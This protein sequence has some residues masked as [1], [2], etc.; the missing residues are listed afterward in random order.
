M[1][2]SITVAR[3]FYQLE[4]NTKGLDRDL[5][6]AEKSF[7]RTAAFIKA[8]PVVAVAALGT[9]MVG[10]ALKATEMASKFE[11]SMAEVST[12]VDTTSVDMKKLADGVLGLYRNLPVE[13]IDDLTKGLYNV[14]SAGVP[15]GEAIEFLDIAARAAV[16]G[17]TNVNTAVGGLT[18]AVNSF[19]T[20]GVTA[21]EAADKFFVAVKGG[22]T[23][24]E[25]ISGSIGNV[26]S[27]ANSLGVSLDDLL[28]NMVALTK[29][30]INTSTAFNSLRQVLSNVAKPTAELRREYPEL[31]K[32]FNLTSLKAK[33]LTQFMLDLAPALKGNDDAAVKMFGSVEALNAVMGLTADGG[34]EL[35]RIQDEMTN[36]AGASAA[37]FDKMA[38]T[39]ANL[40]QIMKNQFA[41]SM[42]ELGV[43][44]LPTVNYALQAMIGFFDTL[45]GATK[46][47]KSDDAARSIGTIATAMDKLSPESRARDLER[48]RLAMIQLTGAVGNSVVDFG[49]FAG[50]ARQ[51]GTEAEK[52][53]TGALQAL[54]KG[55]SAAATS[56]ELTTTQMDHVRRALNGV[57]TELSSRGEQIIPGSA[58]KS[59]EDTTG[60][61]GTTTGALGDLGD[62]AGEAAK[63]AQEAAD[64]YAAGMKRLTDILVQSTTTMVDDT[65]LAIERL[66]DELKAAGIAGEDAARGLRPFQDQLRLIKLNESLELPQILKKSAEAWTPNDVARLRDAQAQLRAMLADTTQ[67][68]PETEAWQEAQDTLFQ[69]T[70]RLREES[71]WNLGLTTATTEQVQAAVKPTQEWKDRAAELGYILDENGKI[72]GST[73]DTTQGLSEKVKNVAQGAIGVAEG[74][75]LIDSKA[76]SALQH[77]VGIADSLPQAF[78]GDPSAIFS[79]LGGLTGVIGSLFGGNSAEE[80]ARKELI[81]KNT[82]A[83][84]ELERTNGNLLRV[85]S[86]G[87]QLS[88]ARDALRTFVPALRTEL[89]KGAFARPQDLIAGF[90]A[91]LLRSGLSIGKLDEVAK[92][93]GINIR[94]PS[95]GLNLAGLT[96]LLEALETGQFTKFADEINEQFDRIKTGIQLGVIAPADELKEILKVLERPDLG[97]GVP[98]IA[99]AF[100]G[101]DVGTAEGRAQARLN[102]QGLFRDLERGTLDEADFGGLNGREFKDI[103]VRL[104]DFLGDADEAAKRAAEEA[105]EAKRKAAEAAE[106]AAIEGDI[107]NVEKVI[108]KAREDLKATLD[109]F[110]KAIARAENDLADPDL[111]ED[112]R[113]V[114]EN[115]LA[116]LRAQLESFKEGG[117][118]LA[119]NRIAALEATLKELQERLRDV[120]RAPTAPLGS[121]PTGA[122]STSVPPSPPA[123]SGISE[124][125][126]DSNTLGTRIPATLDDLLGVNEEANRFL[127]EILASINSS[128][129]MRPPVLPKGF[130]TQSA[131]GPGG[132][133]VTVGDITTHVHVSQPGASA[134]DIAHATSQ[135][136]EETIDRLLYERLQR[137][138]AIR[139]DGGLA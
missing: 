85:N 37:A 116:S 122:P 31:A 115:R 33:G 99:R 12:L 127:E 30:G 98:A 24:F 2:R 117:Q 26:A 19:K 114:A 8:N 66:S 105:A 126:D 106:R 80:R 79:V 72:V 136:L 48:M 121:R 46:R 113:K 134:Q 21:T 22:T 47:M 9:A 45:S 58:V 50:I 123:V 20:Q 44:I 11:K 64:K 139:G 119:E 34:A 1:A 112:E 124:G 38:K 87:F 54:Y 95:G 120:G 129:L 74:F 6:G 43:S 55:L 81:R 88:G 137:E 16:G 130:L 91:Q 86:P 76:A 10:V 83:I 52:L 104:F 75:G 49:N 36:S 67:L 94:G 70:R 15:A 110:A 82:E 78:S 73:K 28:A 111:S 101:I 133:H 32:E 97:K 109:G 41:A 90:S 42:I 68:V 100:S 5:Q 53:G 27:L 107:E 39:N 93:L 125:V 132:M 84:R 25:Q 89:N 71:A 65:E 51:V 7:G 128:P 13:S 102:L 103:L 40:N 4:A 62:A 63:Q 3:L 18:T 92:D 69:V 118:V 61:A 23:T 138:R 56:G 135:S 60:A 131:P 108:A 59:L 96:Q 57:A 17:V 77:V 14:I 35:R 29:N